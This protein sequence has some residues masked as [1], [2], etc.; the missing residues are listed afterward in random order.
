LPRRGLGDW[1]G[2]AGAV[3]AGAV[4]GVGLTGGFRIRRA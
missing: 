1:R 3:V 4:M 2:W